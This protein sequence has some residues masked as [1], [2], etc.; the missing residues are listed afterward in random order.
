[1]SVPV[2]STPRV[3]RGCGQ[4]KPGGTYLYGS[5]LDEVGVAVGVPNRRGG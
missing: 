2:L 5:S 1:M 3:L 4:M